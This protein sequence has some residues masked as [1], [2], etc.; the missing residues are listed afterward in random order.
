MT[1]GFFFKQKT[2]YELRISDWSSDVCS[3]DLGDG[4][5]RR[6]QP[7][8]EDRVPAADLRLHLARRVAHT[9][10]EIVGRLRVRMR[11]IG[12]RREEEAVVQVVGA[13]NLQPLRI[14]REHA[15]DGREVVGEADV[16][17]SEEHTSELQSLMHISYAVFCSKKKKTRR[18]KP[19]P[20]E[21]R[22]Q[23]APHTK[24]NRARK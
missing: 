19:E 8:V 12:A 15:H 6:C 11:G 9:G 21:R 23:S 7:V 22:Q 18:D 13:R 3:S 5:V 16:R 1:V 24:Q 4:I 14:V 2:A 20:L 10:V 17:R